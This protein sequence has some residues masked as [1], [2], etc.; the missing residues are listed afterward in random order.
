MAQR[1]ME[2]RIVAQL[3]TCMD[4]LSLAATGG[5]TVIVMGAT[6]RPD[7]IDPALRRAGR[8]DR[9]IALG[10]P[11]TAARERILRVLCERMRLAGD[12]DLGALAKRCN[13]F[14]GADL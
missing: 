14:V 11:D 2:R 7:A 4:E 12:L 5:Q 10:I 9:E 13:G 3:L 8:F 6:N 1:E